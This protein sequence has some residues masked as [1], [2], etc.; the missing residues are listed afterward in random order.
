MLSAGSPDRLAGA[1]DPQCSSRLVS[2]VALRAK[3]ETKNEGLRN[4][5]V[6]HQQVCVLCFS[7]QE[8]S[9]IK[10]SLPYFRSGPG[11]KLLILKQFVHC[12]D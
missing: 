4:I 2:P 3:V 1:G 7:Q 12:G 5:K 6:L 10:M 11:G 8:R 9:D